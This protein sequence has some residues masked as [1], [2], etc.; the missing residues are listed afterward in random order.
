MKIDMSVIFDIDSNFVTANFTSGAGYPSN[1]L[2]YFPRY[3]LHSP[4]TVIKKSFS[5]AASKKNLV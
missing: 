3:S 2:Q 4:K 1:V 5:K